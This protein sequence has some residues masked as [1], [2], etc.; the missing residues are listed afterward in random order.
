MAGLAETGRYLGIGIANVIV[1]LTPERVV[2]GGGVSG[3]GEL[4][5]APIREEDPRVGST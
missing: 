3:A 5:L 1:L 4:L 2:L